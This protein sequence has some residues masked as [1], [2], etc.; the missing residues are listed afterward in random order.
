MDIDASI[1]ASQQGL[2]SNPVVKGP[3]RE[4]PSRQQQDDSTT[5]LPPRQV[6]VRQGTE[7]SRVQADKYQQEQQ[8]FYEEPN[9]KNRAALDAYQSLA[10]EQ[11]RDEIHQSMGIDTYV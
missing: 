7:E 6:V 2:I 1:I 10:K 4:A 11:L 9:G 5:Q 3:Q 8:R